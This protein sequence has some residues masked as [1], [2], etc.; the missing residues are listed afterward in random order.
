MVLKS[1]STGTHVENKLHAV[2][3]KET[4]TPILTA[5]GLELNQGIVAAE[6]VNNVIVEGASDY[7]YLTALGELL[8]RHDIKFVSGG[9]SG[10]MPKIGTILQ[11]W[12][13]K[14]L[15]LYDNDKAYTD[16]QKSVKKDWLSISKDWLSPLEVDGAVEDLFTKEEFARI[17]RIDAQEILVRNSDFMKTAKKEKVLPARQLLSRLRAGE[18]FELSAQTRET[19]SKLFDS[20]DNAFESYAY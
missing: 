10:N 11:G 6:K 4:I 5:I 3:D 15:Y 12:G 18:V 16:A 14:V 19:A 8:E 1:P 2:S 7:F 9:S 17:L 20:F 13:A